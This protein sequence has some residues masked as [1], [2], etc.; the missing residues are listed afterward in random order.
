M[1]PEDEGELVIR[2]SEVGP[3]FGVLQSIPQGM[4]RHDNMYTQQDEII[5]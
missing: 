5:Y 2:R 4:G 1:D 3:S